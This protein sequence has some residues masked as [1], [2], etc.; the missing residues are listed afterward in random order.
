[1][2]PL[3]RVDEVIALIEPLLV[4]DPFALFPRK[5]L[6]D[7]LFMR[8]DHERALE[9]LHRLMELDNHFW[10]ARFALG[11]A[12]FAQGKL[13]EAILEYERA[14]ESALFPPLVGSLAAA[15]VQAGDNARAQT[16]LARLDSRKNRTNYAKARMFYH[17]TCAEFEEGAAYLEELIKV[18][19]PDV[20]WVCLS[21]PPCREA[22]PVRRLIETIFPMDLPSLRQPREQP[23]FRAENKSQ[24]REG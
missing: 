4:A 12:Y 6:A 8:G 5:T 17:L 22:P 14:L 13:A 1:M 16:L 15:Y 21:P 19:D 11:S 18:R 24:P 7:A 3:G 23:T 2:L 9:E 20:I 10:M